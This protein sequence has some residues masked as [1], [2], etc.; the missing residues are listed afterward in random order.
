[1]VEIRAFRPADLDDLYS[2]CLATGA[3]DDDASALY[4]DPNKLAPRPHAHLVEQVLQRGLYGA[5]R[6]A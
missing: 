5:L 3:G 2:I 1:M 6:D 4:R